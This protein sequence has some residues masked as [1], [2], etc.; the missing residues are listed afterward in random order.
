MTSIDS[1]DPLSGMVNARLQGEA[2]KTAALRG[3][4][5]EG[6]DEHRRE[7]PQGALLQD[8]LW[9]LHHLPGIDVSD[10]VH[11]PQALLRAICVWAMAPVLHLLLVA[12]EERLELGPVQDLVR[13]RRHAF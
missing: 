8:G 5:G 1:I 4:A 12:P 9:Q 10:G 7:I 13:A 2:L 11:H 3:G 6:L